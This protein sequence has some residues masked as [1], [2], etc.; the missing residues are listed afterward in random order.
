MT[1]SVSVLVATKQLPFGMHPINDALTLW[2]STETQNFVRPH[3]SNFL[4]K[5][6]CYRFDKHINGK[7]CLWR[8]SL[9]RLHSESMRYGK[10]MTL[11][12]R[13]GASGALL[14]KSWSFLVP[15]EATK[16]ILFRVDCQAHRR[17]FMH[18]VELVM[19]GIGHRTALA[20][21]CI[22]DVTADR[23]KRRSVDWLRAIV[24]EPFL[25]GFS[26]TTHP[27]LADYKT[28]ATVY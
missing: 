1:C 10:V 3:V 11:W 16:P 17:H 28:F 9:W 2:A 19:R 14:E 4:S 25:V 22:A 8:S 23:L 6:W 26:Q 12:V 20:L 18:P 13:A 24:T 15:G 7:I 21:T 5:Y 27:R